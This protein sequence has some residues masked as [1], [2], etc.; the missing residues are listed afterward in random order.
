MVKRGVNVAE[1]VIVAVGE[2][3]GVKNN[4]A[5]SALVNA[6]SVLAVGVGDPPVFGMTRSEAYKTLFPLLVAAIGNTTPRM[7]AANT[8]RRTIIP[9]LFIGLLSFQQCLS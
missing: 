8:A 4:L 1:G 5:N 7:Q 2:N 3:V 9:W 6:L